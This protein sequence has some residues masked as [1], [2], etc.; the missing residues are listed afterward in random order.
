M[1]KLRNRKRER[2]AIEVAA[3]APLKE[4][5]VAAGFKE[6]PW[7]TYN[8][9]RLSHDPQVAARIAELQEE[10]SDR[11]GIKVEWLQTKLIPLLDADPRKLFEAVDDGAGG[12]IERLRPIS[13]LPSDLAAAVSKI[14]LDPKTGAVTGID[15]ADKNSVGNTLLRSVGGLTDRI[16]HEIDDKTAGENRCFAELA[17]YLLGKTCDLLRR[18]AILLPPGAVVHQEHF[19]EM[20]ERGINEVLET[21]TT[22]PLGADAE[23]DRRL[24]ELARKQRENRPRIQVR[25]AVG[26]GAST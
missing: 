1:P 10:F 13:N 21:L 22:D 8:A 2:F 24:D 3:M 20:V 6:S 7:S 14:R 11:A 9:S 5:Y 4:A 16:E 17:A 25:P 15:L 23:V 18:Y 12:K 26:R 19:L